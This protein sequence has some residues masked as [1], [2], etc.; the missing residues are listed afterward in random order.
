MQEIRNGRGEGVDTLVEL[1]LWAHSTT[2][3]DQAP[4]AREARARMLIVSALPDRYASESSVQ[5]DKGPVERG[6]VHASAKQVEKCM[7]VQITQVARGGV[8]ASAKRTE[9]RGKIYTV[10][11]ACKVRHCRSTPVRSAQV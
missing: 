7:Q 2:I 6:G 11:Q 4:S 1:G 5:R 9:A 3:E 10:K 8:H